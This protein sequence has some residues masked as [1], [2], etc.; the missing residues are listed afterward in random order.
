MNPEKNVFTQ[1]KRLKKNNTECLWLRQ[2]CAKSRCDFVHGRR[3]TAETTVSE[4]RSSLQP[5]MLK[6]KAKTLLSKCKTKKQKCC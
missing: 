6:Q 3:N 1:G 4:H 5:Q 2:H